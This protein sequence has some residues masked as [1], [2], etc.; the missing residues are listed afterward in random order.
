MPYW[1]WSRRAVDNPQSPRRGDVQHLQLSGAVK[2]V[3]SDT[4]FGR[5][6][7]QWVHIWPV[8]ES[9]AL[10][11]RIEAGYV[12]STT[13]RGIPQEQLFRAGGDASIRGYAHQSIG[14]PFN[15]AIVG[16]RYM[17]LAGA[18]YTHWF[19]AQWGAGVFVDTGDAFDQRADFKLYTGYGVGPRWRS[20]VGPINLDLAYGQQTRKFR[21]HFSLGI[22]F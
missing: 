2:S 11:A 12:L 3:L 20:P 5:V 8:G 6:Y 15:N 7:G 17:A 16:G 13:R 4:T 9:D 1:N 14:V 22:V 18:E 21:L 10:S 19:S